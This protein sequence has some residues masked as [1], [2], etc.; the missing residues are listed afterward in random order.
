M[1]PRA[2][3][4]AAAVLTNLLNTSGRPKQLQIRDRHMWPGAIV[5]HRN[6]PIMP[7]FICSNTSMTNDLTIYPT[8]PLVE[9]ILSP[10]RERIGSDFEGYKNHVYR[11]LHCCFALSPCS[12]ED[13]SK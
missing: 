10:W 1:L 9:E 13:R 6:A 12:E 8:L 5:R 2:I 4:F 3:H 7:K 11:M